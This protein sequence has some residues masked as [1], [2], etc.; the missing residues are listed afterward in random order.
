MIGFRPGGRIDLEHRA[1]FLRGG[2]RS[3]VAVAAAQDGRFSVLSA[4]LKSAHMDRLPSKIK[5]ISPH[6]SGQWLA[7]VGGESGALQLQ[8]LSGQRILEVAPP[9]VDG[10]APKWIKPG[11]DD[12]FFDEGGEYLW[13]AAPRSGGECE[14]QLIETGAWTLVAKTVATDPFGGSSCSFQHTGSPGLVSLWLAAGQDGQQVYWLKHNHDG[15]SCTFELHLT[16][17]IPPVFSPT[18]ERFL[19][20]D[21]TNAICQYEFPSLRQIGSPLESR[22]EN[23]PFGTS[24]AYLNERQALANSNEGRIFVVD[25]HRMEIE[26]EVALEGHEPRPIGVYYPILAHESGIGTDISFFQR[27]GSVIFFVYRRDRGKSWEEWK[28][29]LLWVSVDG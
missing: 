11:F 23:D 9:E 16:N 7:A 27:S 19:L 14:I 20:V 6:P 12:C 28:D 29:S 17:T 1:F 4:D 2:P 10:T 15:I 22:D 25:T 5:G 8:D 18:G 24:L 26:D 13:V 3:S 21:E